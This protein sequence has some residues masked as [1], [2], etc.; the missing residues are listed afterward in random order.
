M[1]TAF[2]INQQNAVNFKVLKI[3]LDN[4]ELILKLRKFYPVIEFTSYLI[5]RFNHLLKRDDAREIKMKD[6]FANEEDGGHIKE[7]FLK[8]QKAWNNIGFEGNK[9]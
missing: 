7:L 4:Y 1:Q 8:F 9:I 6:V 2:N 5:N 3:C